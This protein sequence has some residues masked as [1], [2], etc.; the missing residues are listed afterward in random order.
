M[1]GCEGDAEELG[2]VLTGSALPELPESFKHDQI[3]VLKILPFWLLKY[4]SELRAVR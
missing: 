2:V 4:K 3:Y 1:Q